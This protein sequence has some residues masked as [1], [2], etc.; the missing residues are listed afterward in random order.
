MFAVERSLGRAL[1]RGQD[2]TFAQH[3]ID[4]QKV[5]LNIFI[6]TDSHMQTVCF[7]VM[8]GIGRFRLSLICPAIVGFRPTRVR[9]LFLQAAQHVAGYACVSASAATRSWEACPPRISDEQREC[10]CCT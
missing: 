3:A 2:E 7:T 10:K 9:G 8:L 5:E 1:G 6:S 4:A